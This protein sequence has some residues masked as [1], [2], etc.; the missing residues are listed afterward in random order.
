[1]HTNGFTNVILINES[2]I[3]FDE[4]R[5][6]HKQQIKEDEKRQQGGYGLII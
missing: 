3:I 1:M 6:S 5:L 2:S 4:S